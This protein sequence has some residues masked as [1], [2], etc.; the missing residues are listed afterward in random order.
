M[1]S[2]MIK[3]IMANPKYQELVQK[4]GRFAWILSLIVIVVYF[5][6]VL[7]V[8][9]DPKLLA[10]KLYGVTTLAI[11]V[12]VAIIIMSFVLTGV[13]VKRANSEFD[14]MVAEIKNSV[15]KG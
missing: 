8:A 6:F 13:Y 7:I 14:D 5:S 12:G 1:N 9:F 10:I 3:D 2:D 4:R 11:P 15:K